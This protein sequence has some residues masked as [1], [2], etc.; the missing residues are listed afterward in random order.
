MMTTAYVTHS[1]LDAYAEKNRDKEAKRLTKL[2]ESPADAEIEVDHCDKL[3]ERVMFDLDELG[4]V[5]AREK[6]MQDH[7]CCGSCKR[8]INERLGWADLDTSNYCVA[9]VAKS[10]L[11]TC[12][13]CG[14]DHL[15]DDAHGHYKSCPYWCEECGLRVA[16][17][18]A[19]PYS[20][21]WEDGDELCAHCQQE[22]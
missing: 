15:A 20:A 10:G 16:V 17:S 13:A 6:V 21:P 8:R 7:E 9:C 4:L 14:Y 22:S 12:L 18:K 1:P 2:L 3:I 19:K 5:D 11:A